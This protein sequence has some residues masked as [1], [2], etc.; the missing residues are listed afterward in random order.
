MT[1]PILIEKRFRRIS[2]ELNLY[3][4]SRN[5][6]YIIIDFI[7]KLQKE[8]NAITR[9][10]YLYDIHHEFLTAISTIDL[11]YTNIQFIRRI[12][13]CFDLVKQSIPGIEKRQNFQEAKLN[14]IK[15][16][17][18]LKITLDT[19]SI[20]VHSHIE[21][22]ENKQEYSKKGHTS[23]NKNYVNIPI[24][25]KEIILS[26][27]TPRFAKV[28][29]LEIAVKKS[30]HNELIFPSLKNEKGLVRTIVASQNYLSKNF[31]INR[32]NNFT[33]SC[34][35]DNHSVV[36]GESYE[37]GLT[38]LTICRVTH[39]LNLPRVYTIHDN[40]AFTGEI[41]ET[42]NIIPV[43]SE[44]LYL[45]IEACFFSDIEIL[46]VPS[47]N[48][49]VCKNF[50]EQLSK[51]DIGDY[52]LNLFPASK[53]SD[54]IN[55]EKIIKQT[56]ISPARRLVRKYQ[57]NKILKR[58]A[59]LTIFV[60]LI[61]LLL[62]LTIPINKNPVNFSLM[63]EYLL[64][65]NEYGQ[66]ISNIKIGS[67]NVNY[68]M[69]VNNTVL[70]FDA[71]NDK[72][73]EIIFYIR[74]ETSPLPGNSIICYDVKN[75]SLIWTFE[76][77][78]ELLFPNN[79]VY[80]KKYYCR[81]MIIDGKENNTKQNLYALTYNDYYPSILFQIDLIT[82][83][84]ISAYI[85][86]GHLTDIDI[87]DLNNDGK[88]EILLAGVNNSLHSACF[89][90]LDKNDVFGYAPH[91][92]KYDLLNY[93]NSEESAYIL[94]PP[95]I[96]GKRYAKNISWNLIN[97]FQ[98]DPNKKLVRLSINDGNLLIASVMPVYFITLNFALSVVDFNTSDVYDK[99]ADRLYSEGT[100]TTKIDQ[101]YWKEYEKEIAYLKR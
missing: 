73:N 53:I 47:I 52:K 84:E 91:S 45:K 66:E 63:G 95:T 12:L 38:I 6:L 90:V 49:T 42:G 81:E 25:E 88:E 7:E 32:R 62:F 10:S 35:T 27:E 70:F 40:I 22:I 8:E 69:G 24:L 17:S 80:S 30:D 94:F 67:E 48:L 71:N 36:I 50:L 93:S 43:N 54:I 23:I 21:E 72:F 74:D 37:L 5:K 68:L 28:I 101:K 99:L 59:L 33:I 29:Q 1:N 97:D 18:K 31:R 4:S 76:S 39:F 65:M 64:V 60:A 61:S 51:D 89:I 19:R 83:K 98:I 16:I 86:P 9:Y 3:F 87:I 82:G 85:H 15:E 92:A 57:Q 79:P 2:K 75:D 41:D 78:R 96:I 13:S 44:T 58:T 34:V 26:K 56:L 77:K 11:K 20:F 14:L 100:F 55:E 46:V